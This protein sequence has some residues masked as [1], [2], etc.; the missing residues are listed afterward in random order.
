[1]VRTKGGLDH[2][3]LAY[4]TR[5]DKVNFLKRNRIIAGISE[6]TV[7]IESAKKAVRW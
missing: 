3:I 1:M 6:A 4:K 2:R 7:V 5:V